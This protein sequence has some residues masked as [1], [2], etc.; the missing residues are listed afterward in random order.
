MVLPILFIVILLTI[1]VLRRH[2]KHKPDQNYIPDV[3]KD[4]EGKKSNEEEMTNMDNL[5]I[6]VDM[7][8]GQMDRNS[9]MTR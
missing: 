3:L 4:Y 9:G 1:C 7:N 6:K 2:R 8:G 5:P